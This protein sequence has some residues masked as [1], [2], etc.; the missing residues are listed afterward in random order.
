MPPTCKKC[1]QLALGS[2]GAACAKCAATQLWSLPKG[3]GNAVQKLDMCMHG[4]SNK[5]SAWWLP[6]IQQTYSQSDKVS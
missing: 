6:A 3:V 5:A 2:G 1:Q 4:L